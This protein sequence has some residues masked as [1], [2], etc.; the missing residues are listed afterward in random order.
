MSEFWCGL[1][2][3]GVIVCL[4]YMFSNDTISVNKSVEGFFG[5]YYYPY[6]YPFY[7]PYFYSGCNETMFGDI[8]C[9]PFY[10]NPFW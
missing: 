2:F 5:G 7:W 6:D 3:F 10:A 9:L 1:L 8:K 4:F